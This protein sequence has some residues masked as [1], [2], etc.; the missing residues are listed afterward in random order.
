[1]DVIHNNHQK[2]NLDHFLHLSH[3]LALLH[4]LPHLLLKYQIPELFIELLHL[5]IM[6]LF[7]QFFYLLLDTLVDLILELFFELRLKLILQIFLKFLFK[8]LHKLLLKLFFKKS[9]NQL[10]KQ[11]LEQLQLFYLLEQFKELK[12][13]EL[14]PKLELKS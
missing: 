6:M 12:Q 8:L 3:L 7:D 13:R 5:Y 4:N 10:L 2:T 9:L 14:M 1:M 11:L